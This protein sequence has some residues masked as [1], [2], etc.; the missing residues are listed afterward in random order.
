M[1]SER[2]VVEVR[3]DG[4]RTVKR[5][6][7]D[8][9]RAAGEASPLVDELKGLLAQFGIALGLAELVRE[10][11]AVEQAMNRVRVLSGASATEFARLTAAAKNVGST[12]EF[13]TLEAAGALA[14]LGRQGESATQTI[15]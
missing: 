14:Q 4:A 7:E 2:L 11:S 6:I 5:D 8:I 13:S 15:E 1:S 3:S 9:G 12:T 10:F